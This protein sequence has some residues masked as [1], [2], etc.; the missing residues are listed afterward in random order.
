MRKQCKLRALN[1][2]LRGLRLPAITLNKAIGALVLQNGF[3]N[4]S[5]H[6]NFGTGI[7]VHTQRRIIDVKSLFFLRVVSK[8]M[9]KIDGEIKI[10]NRTPM[11]PKI[12]ITVLLLTLTENVVRFGRTKT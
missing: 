10:K 1:S 4:C 3:Q 7:T 9:G 12:G 8:D 11:I 6:S 2:S 5:G